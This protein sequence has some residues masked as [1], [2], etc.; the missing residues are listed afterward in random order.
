MSCFSYSWHSTL[1]CL[2]CNWTVQWDLHTWSSVTTNPHLKRLW[3][4]E[5]NNDIIIFPYR[6]RSCS[7]ICPQRQQW[8]S[9][10]RPGNIKSSFIS[11][12]VKDLTL[13]TFAW[14]KKTNP[15]L[16]LKFYYRLSLEHTELWI[17]PQ[18]MTSI[19]YWHG[20]C[21]HEWFNI[22]RY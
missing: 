3:T 8:N 14:K 1:N 7:H 11:L 20:D 9:Q 21:G 10:R 6:H 4:P 16:Y 15:E 17:S 22:I 12:I 18:I 5:K 13:H 2:K 19:Y